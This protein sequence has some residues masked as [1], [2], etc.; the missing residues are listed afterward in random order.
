MLFRPFLK[1]AYIKECGDDP[2]ISTNSGFVHCA[3]LPRT[4]GGKEG[5]G[6]HPEYW[7]QISQSRI[8]TALVAVVIFLLQVTG[9]HLALMTIPLDIHWCQGAAVR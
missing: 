7:P 8:T 4:P 1:H 2:I 9:I 6:G 5:F 3:A